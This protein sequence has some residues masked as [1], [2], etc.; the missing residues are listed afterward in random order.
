MPDPAITP[1]ADAG[2]DRAWWCFAERDVLRVDGPDATSFLQG[3]LSQDVAALPEGHCAWSLL[4]APTGKLGWWLRV[5]RL[6]DSTYLLDLDSGAGEGAVA[7]LER[8]KLRTDAAVTHDDRWRVIAVRGTDAPEVDAG[9]ASTLVWA[10]AAGPSTVG[11]D[12]IAD[13]AITVASS[14]ATAASLEAARIAAGVPG[15][16]E[17]TDGRIPGELGGWLIESS[18]SFT[19]GCYTGQELVARVNSRGGNVPRHLRIVQWSGPVGP[20][21][22]DRIRLAGD[23][24]GEI[25][26]VAAEQRRALGF[27]GRAVEPPAAVDVVATSGVVAATVS[28]V[29]D[30]P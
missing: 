6:T 4:L 7:R 5:T 17:L 10:P 8:F 26:S 24:V 21:P 13:G 16:A 22:G 20:S 27:V 23:D 25:T 3:Q 2:S 9:S 12:L 18:V 19:K 1:T 11:V 15:P 30:A 28:S 29:P 14:E